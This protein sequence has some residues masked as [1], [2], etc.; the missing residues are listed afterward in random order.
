MLFE[1]DSA[2]ILMNKAIEIDPDYAEAYLERGALFLTRREIKNSISDFKTA[3]KIDP[4][5]TDAIYNLGYVYFQLKNY[6]QA[7]KY[8]EKA[9]SVFEYHYQSYIVIT[10]L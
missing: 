2:E 10:K 1:Y 8:F 4:N 5:Y 7:K 3:L 6:D 9:I